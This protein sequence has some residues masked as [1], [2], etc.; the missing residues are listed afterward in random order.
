MIMFC[1]LYAVEALSPTFFMKK[2]S[3]SVSYFSSDPS[4]AVFIN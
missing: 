1:K 2:K 4:F 3:G